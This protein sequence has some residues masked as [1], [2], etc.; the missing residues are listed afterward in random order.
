M[1]PSF[2]EQCLPNSK[3]SPIVLQK[4][5]DRNW[6]MKE[7]KPEGRIALRRGKRYF[8]RIA[9]VQTLQFQ[10]E[11]K[12]G[13]FAKIPKKDYKKSEEEGTTGKFCNLRESC[14]CA[15]MYFSFLVFLLSVKAKQQ[16]FPLQSRFFQAISHKNSG[17]SPWKFPQRAETPWETNYRLKPHTRTHSHHTEHTLHTHMHTNTYQ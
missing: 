10:Q 15:R 13:I 12:L 11:E 6:K 4:P 8:Y 7:K 3:S 9:R 1:Q 5:W 14:S 17:R 2:W 16:Q